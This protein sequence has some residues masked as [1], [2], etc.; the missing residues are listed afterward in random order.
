[1][2]KRG[3]HKRARAEVERFRRY[4]AAGRSVQ[5]IG[6]QLERDPDE[7]ALLVMDQARRGAIEKRPGGAWGCGK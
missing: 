3:K 4:W 7:V 1:M 6:E 5:E 2:T